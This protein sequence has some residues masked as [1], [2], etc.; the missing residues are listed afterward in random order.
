MG[1]ESGDKVSDLNENWPLGTD[2]KS[3]GDD[4]LRLIKRVLTGD[5]LALETG[6]TV[7]GDVEVYDASG[8]AFVSVRSDPANAAGL[9]LYDNTGGQYRNALT[10]DLGGDILLG[11][12][13][14]G[15]G[16]LLARQ[17]LHLDDPSLFV[18]NPSGDPSPASSPGKGFALTNNTDGPLI[19]MSRASNPALYLSRATTDGTLAVLRRAGNTVGTIGVTNSG[20]SFNTTSDARLKDKGGVADGAASSAMIAALEINN[21]T[22]K[23]DGTPGRGLFAQDAAEVPGIPP[24]L[25]SHDL[26]EDLWSV[27][28][29][30]LVPD[31]LATIQHLQKRLDALESD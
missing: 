19:S 11:S 16:R 14:W 23:G 3:Q 20:A 8:S 6:G 21:F 13:A 5:V 7:K 25:V 27:D 31:L 15:D 1:Y 10:R 18:G 2:P 12:A 4:H 24:D 17:D 29:S 9:R 26:E 22:W 28:Y 30:K